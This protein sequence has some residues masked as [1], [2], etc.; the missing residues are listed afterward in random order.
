MVLRQDER[1]G[2]QAL[3]DDVKQAIMMDMCP[4]GL[5][6]RLVLNSDRNEQG[7]RD[8]RQ[9]SGAEWRKD[10]ARQ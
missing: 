5:E 10:Q 6:R 2:R 4:A 1:T 3:S 8:R 7:K 9:G